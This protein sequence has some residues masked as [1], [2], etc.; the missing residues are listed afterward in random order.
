MNSLGFHI[1]RLSLPKYLTKLTVSL[2]NNSCQ[3]ISLNTSIGYFDVWY[4]NYPYLNHPPYITIPRLSVPNWLN[5][6]ITTICGECQQ[7]FISLRCEKTSGKNTSWFFSRLLPPQT[8]VLT[9]TRSKTQSFPRPG[10]AQ[11]GLLVS[12]RWEV[13]KNPEIKKA[14][15]VVYHG[16]LFRK[17]RTPF[18]V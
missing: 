14:D 2:P 17:P 4:N 9:V 12:D 18:H 6:T 15:P 11:V 10:P 7:F 13:E 3:I 8:V 5:I 16:E 1:F